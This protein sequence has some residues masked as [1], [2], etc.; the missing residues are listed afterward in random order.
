MAFFEAFGA[1]CGDPG[2]PLLDAVLNGKSLLGRR[3][4]P[5][6]RA[7][8]ARALGRVATAK[9]RA[10]LERAMSERDVVVRNAVNRAVRE[11]AG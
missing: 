4:E 9:A 10:A 6:L 1:L 8:A 7:C 11:A 2:V 3:E 5:E